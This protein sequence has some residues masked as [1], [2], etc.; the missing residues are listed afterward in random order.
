MSY[1]SQMYF[2]INGASPSDALKKVAR[3]IIVDTSLDL[4]DMFSIHFDD[5]S[6]TCIDSP[7]L[8]IGKSI[9]IS[10]RALGDSDPT[11]LMKGEIVAIEP[12][13]TQD[14]GMTI[15]IRGYD[16]S[17]RLHRGKKTKPFVNKTDSDIVT[18]IAQRV[19]SECRCGIDQCG[20]RTCHSGQPD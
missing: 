16:K 3:E 9:E 15:V 19:R 20:L 7:D 2:K 13:L 6:L 5:P 4:P 17:H 8:E 1:L 11:P 14:I 12:E 10:G 18:E